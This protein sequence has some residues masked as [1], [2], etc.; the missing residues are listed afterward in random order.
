[1]HVGAASVSKAAA[2]AHASTWTYACSIRHMCALGRPYKI[3]LSNPQRES[4]RTGIK[5]SHAELAI[6]ASIVRLIDT[7]FV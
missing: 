3:E 2:T 5:P 6:H 4:M 1:M 7:A